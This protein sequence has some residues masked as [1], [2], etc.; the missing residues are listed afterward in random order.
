MKPNSTM[1]SRLILCWFK[2]NIASLWD[3]LFGNNDDVILG[4]PLENNETVFHFVKL[5]V[6]LKIKNGLLITSN[7]HDWS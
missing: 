2:I 3:V 4:R 6:S 7:T 1:F 5:N